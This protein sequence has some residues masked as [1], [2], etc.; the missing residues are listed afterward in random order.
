MVCIY[1]VHLH[2]TFTLY[3]CTVHLHCTFT[4]YIYTVHLHCRFRL[5]IYTESAG[6]GSCGLYS[7]G[8]PGGGAGDLQLAGHRDNDVPK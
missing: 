3:I 5:Y 4:L 7:P 2:Y 8:S 6:R 1:T